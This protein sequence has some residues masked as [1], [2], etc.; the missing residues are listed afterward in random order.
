MPDNLVAFSL[1][2]PEANLAL[3]RGTAARKKAGVASLPLADQRRRVVLYSHD[4][5]GLG[6]LRRNLAIAEELLAP[7]RDFDVVLLSGSPVLGDWPLPK[8]L[9]V[10]AL[11]PVVKVGAEK[12]VPRGGAYPF[13][14]VKGYREGVILRTVMRERPDI[15]LVDH[16]PSGMKHE[17]LS[18]L[19]TV[20]RDMPQ[21]RL[22]LG[23]R[24]IIDSPDAVRRL[25]EAEEVYDLLDHGYDQILVYGNRELYDI[26]EAYALPERIRAKL[27][28]VGYVARKA[29]PAVEGPWPE[30]PKAHGARVLVTLGGGGDGFGVMSAYLQALA[31]LPD[32]TTASLLIPGPL[33]SVEQGRALAAAAG[34]R[35]DVALVSS[36]HDL[37]ALIGRADLVVA[38][39]G[40]NTTTEVLAARKPAI[41]VPRSAPRL[42]QW[43]RAKMLEARGLVYVAEFGPNLAQDLARLIKQALAA[44]K[45][46]PPGREVLDLAGA[47]RTADAL[48]ALAPQKTRRRT[49]Y[50]MKRYPRLSETFILNEICAMEA[51]GEN[52]E[53]F[54]LLPPEPPPHHP[55][56][57]R[58]KAPLTFPPIAF[59]NKVAAFARAHA[60]V[61]AAA[62]AG[63]ASALAL[64]ARR[65]LSLVAR[66][67]LSSTSPLSSARQ[68]LRAGFFAAEARRRGVTHLHAH[69]AN[70]PAAVA[71]VMSRMLGIPFS[72]TAHAK[73]LYLTPASLIAERTA[74]AAFVATCT[75]YNVGYFNDILPAEQRAKINLVYHGVDLSR[76]RYRTPSY[77]FHDDD[78]PA[79][80]LSVG[81][82]VPKK[83]L[84]DLIEACAQ[85]K[86]MG[87]AF[88]CRIVGEG[89]LRAALEAAIATRGL[90]G[91]VKLEGAMT[92]D[93]LVE[94]FNAADLF[95]LSPRIMDDGDRD[96]I[97]N[98]IVEAA[99]TGVPI[100]T[101]AISGIPEL[102]EDGRTGLLVPSNDPQ[103][104][105]LAMS[106]LLEDDSLG[107]EMAAAVR[108]RLEQCF[109]CGR[110]TG[111][112]RT[113]M[114]RRVCESV[115]AP[116]PVALAA[117]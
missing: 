15:F 114:M 112:L 35:S 76:F 17:L 10:Q 93:K 27:N 21:T 34:G 6:H 50:I 115:D 89:P 58:V 85:L 88:R 91:Q 65:T 18:T 71:E 36:T 19:A 25:W 28:Y 37:P 4:T 97:P 101:T 3:A 90:D 104:L 9:R 87:V 53:I 11:P 70:A 22:V 73:D 84:D 26:G 52:L 110:N 95:V 66:R 43:L 99:A 113:L 30:L 106:R 117:E 45:D 63:Y 61:M 20:K 14:L 74:A 60:E 103:A 77:A 92:Q 32:H 8:G 108:A 42:E 105:A 83:G 98:V 56:V 78:A 29:A 16:A 69:F 111:A 7:G 79:S 5:F 47:R 38:M 116:G 23:L 31:Q 1:T 39:G 59:A 41:L 49:A 72:F 75:H 24:D 55:E 81:R 100:V 33:M 46:V 86:D 109:D 67:T 40:Y 48:E 13:S 2:E 80:I 54:S 64:V 44:A 94:L 96:G 57:A 102:I 51:L 62:P 12:Y 82:L 107:R 68:F